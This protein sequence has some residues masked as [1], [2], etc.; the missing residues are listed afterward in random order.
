M[1]SSE[2]A[3]RAH[4]LRDEIERHRYLYYVRSETEISDAAFDALM[5][6]LEELETQFP[7]LV[8]IDSPT[9]RVG[10]PIE[11]GFKK[12]THRSPM[13][14]L[15][16]AFSLD[17]LERWEARNKKLVPDGKFEYFCELKYD[18]VSIALHY[19]DG[20]LVRGV[21][22]GDGFIGEDVTSNIRAIPSIPLRLRERATIEIRGEVYMRLATLERV[23]ATQMKA[24]KP[25]YANPRNLAA[26]TLRQLDPR[27]VRERGLECVAFSVLGEVIPEHSLEHERAAELGMPVDP[28]SR[29]CRTLT[30]V[31]EFTRERDDRRVGLPYQID[32]LVVGINDR[33]TVDRLGIVGRA[34][35]AAIA[36]KFAA[37]EVTT[38]VEDIRVNVGR[39]GVLTPFAVMTPVQ[40]AGTTVSMATLH[41]LDEI[42]RKDIRVSDTVIIRKAGDIIPEVVASLPKLRTG[43][44]KVFEMPKKCPNCNTSIIRVDGE[45]A[46]RCPNLECFAIQ[47]EGVIHFA[48]RG[49][50][51]IVGL[52]EK[53][54]RQLLDAKLISDP[55]DIYALG[56]G[57]LEQLPLFGERRAQKLIESIEVR[58]ELPLPRLIFGLGIRHVGIETAE[59][60]AE[61]FGSLERLIEASPEDLDEVGGIGGIVAQSIYDWFRTTRHR[62]LLDKFKKYGVRPVSV[63]RQGPLEGLSVVITGTL[64]SMSREQAEERVK[65][66]GG[67]VGG[68]VTK[69]T[70]YLVVGDNPGE[71]KL[72]QAK[73]LDVRIISEDDLWQLLAGKRL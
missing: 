71:S 12:F 6:E 23:N 3:K 21:T 52:G 63:R 65:S 62:K 11:G 66:L 53:V 43:K 20:L 51:D 35:R 73:K 40:V 70:N 7:E 10:A 29:L 13:L 9:Q 27:M 2:A 37:E 25:A 36:Y 33:Q 1:T 50:A 69:S 30:E 34:P 39:T 18:G 41:N 72:S 42:R 64:G 19:E 15:T 16:D 67:K 8:T 28:H 44:E 58:K 49:A 68:S 56:Q 55:A 4:K 17:E 48:S 47:C 57:D 24:D 61:H 38:K 60:L 54:A 31:E 22:R 59:D 5:H 46:Y 32:G 26:G 14:S 45:A